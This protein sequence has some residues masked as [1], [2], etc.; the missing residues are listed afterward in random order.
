MKRI[1]T[2]IVL[3]SSIILLSCSSKTSAKH[4]DTFLYEEKIP[5]TSDSLSSA[6]L[7]DDDIIGKLDKKII[8]NLWQQNL[9]KE[10]PLPNQILL[11]DI[12][13]DGIS[14]I[15]IR[16]CDEDIKDVYA[17]GILSN[18]DGNL[19]WLDGICDDCGGRQSI[20]VTDKGFI[21]MTIEAS[22][23]AST[24]Y[25]K[26]KNS[27]VDVSYLFNIEYDRWSDIDEESLEEDSSDE[28]E[29]AYYEKTINGKTT[30]ITADEFNTAVDNIGK[31]I[32]FY[33]SN[34]DSFDWVEFEC[35]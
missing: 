32:E 1:L 5:V 2:I 26:I 6:G 11:Y 25:K 18:K 9:G 16:D 29:L 17:I 12:D 20:S 15:I 22:I 34:N 8:C 21:V 13:G 27:E 10:T 23:S 19:K 24:Y 7:Q 30:E 14:E 28:P 4:A 3:V 31:P 35:E 33:F